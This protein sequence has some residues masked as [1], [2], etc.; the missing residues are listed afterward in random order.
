MAI[1]I[2]PGRL[3]GLNEYTKACRTNPYAGA[4]MKKDGERYVSVYIHK[5]L[6]GMTV[7]N[8]VSITFKW[9]ERNAR[10]DPDNVSGFGHKVILDAMVHAGVLPDDSLN[11]VRHI[12]DYFMVDKKNPR[13]EVEI[14]EA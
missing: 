4:D 7:K 11:W 8:P 9:H 5:Q 13:I 1:L 6:R 12:E 3:P 14:T 10:R 2:I